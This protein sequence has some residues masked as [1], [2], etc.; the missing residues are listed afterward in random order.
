MNEAFEFIKSVGVPAGIAFF[1]LY[2]LDER[3]KELVAEFREFRKDVRDSMA[4]VDSLEKH[5]DEMGAKVV[6]DVDHN[7][8]GLLGNYAVERAPRPEKL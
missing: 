8:R 5:M 3:F 7:I 6:R 2:R 1:V 4:N